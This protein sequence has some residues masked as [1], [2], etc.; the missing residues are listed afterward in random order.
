MVTTDDEIRAL[1]DR[2][3]VAIQE[4]RAADALRLL[5]EARSRMEAM[6]RLH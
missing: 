6:A 3:D 1:L 2:V 4:G 5:A